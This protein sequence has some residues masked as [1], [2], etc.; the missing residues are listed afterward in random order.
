MNHLLSPFILYSFTEFCSPCTKRL[1]P[2]RLV[3]QMLNM[4][5]FLW[6]AKW[7]P[8]GKQCIRPIQYTSCMGTGAPVH[9]TRHLNFTRNLSFFFHLPLLNTSVC[10]LAHYLHV[11][12]LLAWCWADYNHFLRILRFH[13]PTL[14][15]YFRMQPLWSLSLMLDL[16]INLLVQCLGWIWQC[17]L[18]CVSQNDSLDPIRKHIHLNMRRLY[19]GLTSTPKAMIFNMHSME[20][21]EVNTMFRLANTAS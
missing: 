15:S 2:R 8:A 14:L 17:N 1:M 9:H 12:L 11:R 20:K 16:F 18:N 6:A 3:A 10:P 21:S 19:C 4:M 13:V 5:A 7:L